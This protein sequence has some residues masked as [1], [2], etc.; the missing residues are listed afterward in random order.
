MIVVH[1]LDHSRSLRILWLLEELGV[2]YEVERYERMPDY[3][4]PPSLLNVHP[5]GKSPV[6]EDKDEGLVL[7]ESN[8]IISYILIVWQRLRRFG[9]RTP[10]YFRPIFQYV[11]GSY[12]KM[13]V[14]LELKKNSDMIE[15]HLIDHSWFA[16]GSD[17]PT[18]ADYAMI[19]GLEGL[20]LGK[21]VDSQTHPRIVEYVK[22]VHARPAYQSGVKKS[23][24]FAF[25]KEV[26]TVEK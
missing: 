6:I 7:A 4:A 22:K 25:A 21:A 18:A 26:D 13:Y 1:H 10:W 12:R 14:D 24:E 17:E 16:R 23:R 19:I 20:Y 15:K 8:A 2:P 11:L 9:N 3:Q 5:L